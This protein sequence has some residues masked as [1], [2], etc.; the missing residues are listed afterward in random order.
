MKKPFR[1]AFIEITN[2]CNLSCGFCATSSRPARSMSLENFET[3]A[4]QVKPLAS[5]ISL[6]VLGEPFMHPRLP[7]ILGACSRLG[8]SVNLVTNGTLL[9]KFGPGIFNEPCLAQV[10]FSLHALSALPAALRPEKLGR[11]VEFAA[12]RPARLIVGFRLRGNSGDPFVSGTADYILK[13]FSHGDMAGEK[14][15]S[16]TL[17]DKVFLN[18]GGLFDWP[19]RSPALLVHES[20]LSAELNLPVLARAKRAGRGKGKEKKGCL[21]LR[22]HF[23]VL[24]G[25]QVVPCCAD[26]D[27][28]LAIGNVNEKPLA[29][30]LGGPAASRL[31]DSIAAKTPMPSYCATCGFTAP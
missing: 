16:I 27:G 18:F 17:R 28:H 12:N 5:V 20:G 4:A 29:A 31:R 22:H 11:C 14:I 13:A 24:C 8:L 19:G 21:G 15:H 23:A 7:E 25:G 9:D 10:S 1:R 3:I 26:Y 6:H 2:A 30:I